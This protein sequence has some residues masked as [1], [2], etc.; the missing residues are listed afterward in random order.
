MLSFELDSNELAK[1]SHQANLSDNPSDKL[2][3]F[4]DCFFSPSN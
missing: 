4:G 2:I 3:R 1:Q